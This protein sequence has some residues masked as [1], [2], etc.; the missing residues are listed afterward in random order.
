MG[1][2]GGTTSKTSCDA[3]KQNTAAGTK[4]E[5]DRR[6]GRRRRGSR[7]VARQSAGTR[8]CELSRLGG[9][10]AAEGYWRKS[11]AHLSL[12]REAQRGAGRGA[13]T[14]ERAEGCSKG[15]QR[16][17][18][19][20]CHTSGFPVH[21]EREERRKRQEAGPAGPSAQESQ[22]EERGRG[23]RQAA[24]DRRKQ[25]GGRAVGGWNGWGFKEARGGGRGG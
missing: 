17:A 3:G 16:H 22:S 1:A 11:G 9:K 23:G 6:A 21:R 18:A 12:W 13:R 10:A 20:K 19:G 7:A 8:R 14:R 4:Q 24:E 2:S 25:G 15:R 5:S